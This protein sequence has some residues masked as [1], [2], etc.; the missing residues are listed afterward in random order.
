MKKRKGKQLF[1]VKTRGLQEG[2]N[3]WHK[4]RQL[5]YLNPRVCLSNQGPGNKQPK[6]KESVQRPKGLHGRRP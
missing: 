1:V 2:R 4:S 6:E 5:M 3:M